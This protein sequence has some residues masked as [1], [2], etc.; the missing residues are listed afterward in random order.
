MSLNY[1]PFESDEADVEAHMEMD[2]YLDEPNSMMSVAFCA[3]AFL[4]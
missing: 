3:D 2:D 1:L 4:G